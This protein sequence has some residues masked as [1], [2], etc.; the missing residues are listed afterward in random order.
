MNT[1]AAKQKT[2]PADSFFGMALAQ[3][4]MGVAFGA[5]VDMAWEACETASALYTDRFERKAGHKAPAFEMGRENSLTGFF[6]ACVKAANTDT[7]P[8]PYFGYDRKATAP[9]FSMAA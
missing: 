7:T 6:D 3:A 5:S 8:E 1:N 2:S 4:F 9:K